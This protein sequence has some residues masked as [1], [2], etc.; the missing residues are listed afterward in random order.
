MN[1][2]TIIKSYIFIDS[3][4]VVLSEENK[5]VLLNKIMNNLKKA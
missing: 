1:E 5:K 3:K 4:T 2:D